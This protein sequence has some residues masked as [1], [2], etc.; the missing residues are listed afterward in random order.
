MS[1]RGLKGEPGNG[2]VTIRLSNRSAQPL[3]GTLRFKLPASW[4][5]Q[6][7]EIKV[8][9][10]KPMEVRDVQAK[11]QWTPNWKEGETARVEYKSADGR[12][13]EQPLIP[14]RLTIYSAPNLVMDGDL[15]D[16]PAKTKLPAWVLGSTWGAAN[17]EV[18]LAWSNQGLHV[19]VAGSRFQSHRARPAQFLGGRC[20]GIVRRHARSFERDVAPII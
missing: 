5:T 1:V 4:N 19:A 7:P 14:S 12:T 8:E 11:V 17:A 9:A 15:K 18:Y 20:A 2:D 3:D 10:L 13:A 6:T 16:W